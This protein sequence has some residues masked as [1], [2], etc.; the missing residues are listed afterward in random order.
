MQKIVAGRKA[1]EIDPTRKVLE[2][3]ATEAASDQ[4]MSSDA[5]KRINDMLSFVKML[6][7]WHNQVSRLPAWKLKALVKMGSAVQRFV[8]GKG[9]KD[10]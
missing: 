6:D 8:G 5:R 9:E 1:R 4:N 2:D 10:E 3:C 7:T